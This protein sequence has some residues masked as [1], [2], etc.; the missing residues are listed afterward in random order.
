MHVSLYHGNVNLW[1]SLSP[2]WVL[3]GLASISPASTRSVIC[4]VTCK[5]L[6][7]FRGAKLNHAW[8][9]SNSQ[10]NYL[11]DLQDEQAYHLINCQ[12]LVNSAV[13]FS[14]NC[15]MICSCWVLQ[16]WSKLHINW[17]DGHF[18]FCH[19]AWLSILTWMILLEHDKSTQK[20]VE[21]SYFL[22]AVLH[23]L[24]LLNS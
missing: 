24:D 5:S 12:A 22:R 3:T 17:S 2:L 18:P 21:S 13:H 14:R 1:L 8:F 20:S 7:G 16:E 15:T 23:I 19:Q 9:Q 10:H 4:S 11:L 6:L